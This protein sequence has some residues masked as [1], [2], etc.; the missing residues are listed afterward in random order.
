MQISLRT[1]WLPKKGNTSEE[2][3]DAFWPREAMNVHSDR[4]RF[5][6]ADGATESSFAGSW[7]RLLV[8]AYC[9]D[10]LSERKIRKQLPRLQREW[11]SGLENAP[12][13]WY[14]EEKL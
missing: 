7:A 8:R 12:L 11:Y 1:F 2:Y 13:P 10:Q 14:A 6:V 3:E 9:R 5:A 4:F